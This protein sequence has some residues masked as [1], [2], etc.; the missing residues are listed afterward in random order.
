[1]RTTLLGASLAALVLASAPA[2][3]QDPRAASYLPDNNIQTK[4]AF[5]NFIPRLAEATGGEVEFVSLTG[6]V[7]LP[8][9]SILMGVGGGVAQMGFHST[10]YTPSELPVAY[11][12]SGVGFENPDPYVLGFAFAD[13]VMH[14]TVVY[15]DFRRN[16][17]IPIGGFSTPRYLLICN[18]PEPIQSPD[19]IRGKK[20]RFPGGQAAKLAD[21]LRLTPVSIP[22]PE[23]YQALQNGQVD[24]AGIFAT[25]LDIDMQLHEVARSVTDLQLPPVFFDAMQ[26]YNADFWQGLTPEQRKAVFDEAARSM[27]EMTVDFATTTEASFAFAAEQDIPIVTPDAEL[28]ASINEW[29]AAGAG[30]MVGEA[31]RLGVEDPEAVL[32]S[33]R[34]YVEKWDG[35]MD[36]VSDPNDADELTA[37]LKAEIFDTLD[38]ATYGAE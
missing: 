10:N 9:K 6:G 33:F 34:A 19:D 21:H 12:V 32:A 22:A 1:M 3:A 26:V 27:A 16:G 11:S 37:L 30:D 31:R 4:H 18:T 29:I 23:M 25:Y 8:A 2:L 36:G 20:I 28:A 17:V 7:L 13:W 38:P 24:C 14:E 35:L 5:V 15:D